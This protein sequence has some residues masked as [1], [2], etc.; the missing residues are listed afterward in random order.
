MCERVSFVC[1]CMHRSSEPQACFCVCV[2][3]PFP[4]K[5]KTPLFRLCVCVCVCVCVC[6]CLSLCLCLCLCLCLL[7]SVSVSGARE[8][9]RKSGKEGRKR[10]S[11]SS[12]CSQSTLRKKGCSHSIVL[13][14]ALRPSI[15]PFLPPSLTHLLYYSGT[16]YPPLPSCL[17]PFLSLPPPPTLVYTPKHTHSHTHTH[18]QRIGVVYGVP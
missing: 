18:T 13:P 17:P 6:L 10:C 4:K 9:A 5:K 3:A 8:R 1:V 14:P 15:L 12:V 7:M 16:L 2:C 11:S